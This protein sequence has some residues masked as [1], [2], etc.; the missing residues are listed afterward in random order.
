MIAFIDLETTGTDDILD[1]ILEV[2]IV[3]VRDEPYFDVVGTFSVVVAQDTDAWERRLDLDPYV[4][5]M[6]TTNG[7][8]A[9]VREA[10]TGHL[11]AERLACDFLLSHDKAG[12]WKMAGSGVS[13]FDRRFLREQMPRLEA[14]FHYSHVDV[15]VVRRVLE[16]AGRKDLV[17]VPGEGR[18]FGGEFQG[19]KDALIPH[20]GLDDALAHY[21]EF[22]QY[23]KLLRAIPLEYGY[24]GHS[25]ESVVP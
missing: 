6:H 25:L 22:R 23:V 2:G 11:Q 14:L 24:D 12:R 7:L 18:Q 4:R 13:H 15:G 3:A 8:A 20:R 1:P 9:E 17:P 10:T 16:L 21:E 5:E 19:S